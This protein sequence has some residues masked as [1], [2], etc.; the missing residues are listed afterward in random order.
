MKK[1][2][3]L[4]VSF[5]FAAIFSVSAFA[6]PAGVPAAAPAAAK[7]GWINTSA[8]GGDDKGLNGVTRYV[9]ALKTLETE[10]KPRLTELQTLDTR[11]KGIATEL[12]NMQKNTAVPVNQQ[13]VLAKQEEGQKLQRELEF[14]QKDAEAA[15][16][17]RRN[18]L[19][20]PIMGDIDKALQEFSKQKGYGVVLDVAA[21]ANANAILVLD[22]AADI[23]GAEI[24][25]AAGF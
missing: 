14:K 19:L 6:Q 18:T 5:I 9:N 16:Q 10:F 25:F 21:L 4:A 13:T 15:V 7:I 11:I 3:T 8:F 12:E 22:P 24:C 23:L 1:V 17:A 2:T 20:G